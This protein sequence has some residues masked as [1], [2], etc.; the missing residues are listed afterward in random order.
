M[1]GVQ[2]VREA[3]SDFGKLSRIHK[4]LF[5]SVLGCRI[6]TPVPTQRFTEIVRIKSC[7]LPCMTRYLLLENINITDLNFFIEAIQSPPSALIAQW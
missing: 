1:Y 4:P 6:S 7:C 3:C 2:Y 5:S